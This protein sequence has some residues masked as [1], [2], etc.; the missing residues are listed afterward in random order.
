MSLN[1]NLRSRRAW[2]IVFRALNENDF[3]P[4][5]LYPAKLSFKRDGAMKILHDK[6][7]LKQYITTKPPL[8]KI[9]QGILNTENKSKQNHERTGSIKPQVVGDFNTPLSTIDRS[10]KQKN[11]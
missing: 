10:S 2:S 1:G 5:I 9:L 4:R 7:K 11:Q 6:Q 3:N 8:Q